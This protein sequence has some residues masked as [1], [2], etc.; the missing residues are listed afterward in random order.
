MDFRCQHATCEQSFHEIRRNEIDGT[1]NFNSLISDY[2]DDPRMWGI[3][4]M[5]MYFFL[6]WDAFCCIDPCLIFDVG[7]FFFT[8]FMIPAWCDAESFVGCTCCHDS[9]CFIWDPFV[10]MLM[11]DS[12]IAM[13][14]Y[15]EIHFMPCWQDVHYHCAWVYVILIGVLF[16]WEFLQWNISWSHSYVRAFSLY[17]S[18][19]TSYVH[20]H[21]CNT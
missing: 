6:L 8:C 2:S 10:V 17:D 21:Y 15:I 12:C 20:H 9:S 4:S 7:S 3:C 19:I 16:E 1:T 11:G 18:G 14:D 13:Y 5:F